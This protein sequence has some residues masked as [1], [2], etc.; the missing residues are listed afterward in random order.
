MVTSNAGA[1]SGKS[2]PAPPPPPYCS[3]SS[4]CTKGPFRS[5]GDCIQLL[6]YHK[7]KGSFWNA[8]GC[9]P[10][11]YIIVC[12]TQ[13][14]NLLWSCAMV[15]CLIRDVFIFGRWKVVYV[16]ELE[17][18]VHSLLSLFFFLTLWHRSNFIR[19]KALKAL[20]DRLQKLEQ[21][22]S[23]PALDEP[24]KDNESTMASVE[25]I[26]DTVVDQGTNKRTEGLPTS[27][28]VPT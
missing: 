12:T 3:G 25:E 17:Y 15:K 20:N 9:G 23:W 22:T 13:L 18:A 11:L 2:L 4:F 19:Q 26:P 28:S 24:G 6:H 10:A 7:L 21:N 8:F 16:L 27:S 14:I 5:A 1:K